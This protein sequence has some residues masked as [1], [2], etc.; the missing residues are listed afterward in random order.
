MQP[1]A[2]INPQRSYLLSYSQ[3]SCAASSRITL[4][5]HLYCSFLLSASPYSQFLPELPSV[6]IKVKCVWNQLLYFSPWNQLP[7]PLGFNILQSVPN[8]KASLTVFVNLGCCNIIDYHRL[9]SLNSIFLKF[10]RLRSLRSGCRCFLA[11]RQQTYCVLTW[12]R[13]ERHKLDPY[14]S[15]DSI[16]P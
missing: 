7:T 3:H 4:G 6:L 9:G 13:A 12:P 11:W 10:W 15:T 14:K 8:S 1:F 2:P 5:L 16:I